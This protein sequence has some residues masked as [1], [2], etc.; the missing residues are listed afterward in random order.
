LNMKC[1]EF[2]KDW[3]CPYGRS[4][5]WG[6]DVPKIKSDD[7]YVRASAVW[8][9]H[10]LFPI[11]S[12]AHCASPMSVDVD[13]HAS[14]LAP[15][16]VTPDRYHISKR[17]PCNRCKENVSSETDIKSMQPQN[18]S[19]KMGFSFSYTEGAVSKICF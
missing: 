7:Y 13:E 6:Q 8:L 3:K 2:F 9:P 11:T 10:T 12:H 19:C 4:D 17:Y 18:W 1:D 15:C 16:F 5:Y 14:R